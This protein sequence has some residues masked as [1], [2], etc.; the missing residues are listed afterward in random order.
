MN[1]KVREI[2]SPYLSHQPS[3]IFVTLIS[4]IHSKNTSNHILQKEDETSRIICIQIY[5]HAHSIIHTLI[6]GVHLFSHKYTDTVSLLVFKACLRNIDFRFQ[7]GKKQW[8]TTF[9]RLG[10]P[11][12]Q[13]RDRPPAFLALQYVLVLDLDYHFI[14]PG[15]ENNLL[16]RTQPGRR[17]LYVFSEGL[18]YLLSHGIFMPRSHLH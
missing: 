18:L 3:L 6:C 4:E 9:N 8:Q 15:L 17:G 5:T 13:T 12:Q 7:W 2:P 10:E 1:S 11:L 14:L 16:V